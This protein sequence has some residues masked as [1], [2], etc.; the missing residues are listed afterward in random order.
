MTNPKVIKDICVLFVQEGLTLLDIQH[1]IFKSE[2]EDLFV[3]VIYYSVQGKLSN[4]WI[5]MCS[6]RYLYILVSRI[7]TCQDSDPGGKKYGS[8]SESLKLNL[9]HH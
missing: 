4:T 5:F 1:N 8:C 7:Q 9:T 2:T 6:I 3:S